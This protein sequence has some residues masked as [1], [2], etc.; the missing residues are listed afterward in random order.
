MKKPYYWIGS[1]EKCVKIFEIL[2]Q[3]GELSVS[4][5]AADLDADRSSVFRFWQHCGILDT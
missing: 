1:A 2:A 5:I 4:E 3:R